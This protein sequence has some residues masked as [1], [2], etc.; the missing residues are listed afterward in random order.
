MVIGNPEL[1]SKVIRRQSRQLGHQ[2]ITSLV[3][4]EPYI[5]RKVR[6]N[7]LAWGLSSEKVGQLNLR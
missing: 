4:I 2:Y 1:Y 6:R 7:R 3:D 5:F